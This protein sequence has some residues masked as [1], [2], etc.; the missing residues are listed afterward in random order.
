MSEHFTLHCFTGISPLIF[1]QFQ[2]ESGSAPHSVVAVLWQSL[3]LDLD[4][5]YEPDPG[6]EVPHSA[7]DEAGCHVSRRVDHA[8]ISFNAVHDRLERV[9][10]NIFPVILLN[11]TSAR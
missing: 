10:L 1:F 7:Q 8:R 9:V 5:W 4:L 2:H 6:A 3:H 11:R